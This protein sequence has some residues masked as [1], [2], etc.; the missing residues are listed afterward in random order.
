VATKSISYTETRTGAGG[1]LSITIIEAEGLSVPSGVN[2]PDIVQR[3]V[4]ENPKVGSL[5]V[6][7]LAASQPT[8]GDRKSNRDDRKSNRDG[9]QRKYNWWLPCECSFFQFSH[10]LSSMRNLINGLDHW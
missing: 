3:A 1:T 10:A 2:I 9:I 8:P 5:T 4:V 7:S 6:G